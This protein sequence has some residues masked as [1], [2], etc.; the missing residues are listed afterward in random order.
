MLVV[1]GGLPGVGKS[2]IAQLVAKKIGA[3]WLRID[4]IEQAMREALALPE[5]IADGGYAVAYKL[6]EANLLLGLTVIADGVNP[7]A[8]TRNSWREVAARADAILLE[9]EIVCSDSC[10]HR[11]RV[12]GR[13]LEIS[14][15]RLPNWEEVLARQYEPWSTADMAIDSSTLGPGE[16]ATAIISAMKAKCGG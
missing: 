3:M 2:A 8:L 13:P 11:R 4:I 16:A 10:E 14:G 9:V 12:E 7:I 15:L 6:A 1:L 5:D